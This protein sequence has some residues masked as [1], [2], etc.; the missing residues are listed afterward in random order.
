M[1]EE[2]QD[3]QESLVHLWVKFEKGKPRTFRGRGK[4]LEVQIQRLVRNIVQGSKDP[5]Q[6]AILYESAGERNELMRWNAQRKAIDSR[7][8]AGAEYYTQAWQGSTQKKH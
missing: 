8:T 3:S 4:T 1:S 2:I 6:V 5:Y 7:P